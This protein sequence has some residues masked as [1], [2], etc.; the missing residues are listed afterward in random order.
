MADFK[1]LLKAFRLRSC[2][3]LRRFAEQIGESPG[4]YAGVESG[5][6]DPWRDPE[7]LRHVAEGLGLREG[8]ADWD[9]FFIAAKDYVGLPPLS[10]RI[11]NMTKI[12]NKLA[13]KIIAAVR[14]DGRSLYALA[15]DSGIQRKQL[16][17]FLR[18]QQDMTLTVAARLCRE[19][20]LEIVG[21]R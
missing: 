21:I 3:G 16:G 18:G 11:P 15:R 10:Q 4:N 12:T 17:L 5:Q 20:H 2:V 1:T 9:A 6:R 8:S 19:L 7:K 14:A 13:A